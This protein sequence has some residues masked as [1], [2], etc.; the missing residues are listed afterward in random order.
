MYYGT[1]T[2]RGRRRR[3][4]RRTYSFSMILQRDLWY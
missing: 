2:M 1:D 3:R 4:R